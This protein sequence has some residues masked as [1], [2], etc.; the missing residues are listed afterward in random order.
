MC[1]RAGVA[2]QLRP[3]DLT[4]AAWQ[5]LAEQWRHWLRAHATGSFG[6]TLDAA[7]GRLCV[8]GQPAGAAPRASVH[9]LVD[10]V[11]GRMQVG[12]Q[13]LWMTSRECMRHVPDR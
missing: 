13:G 5:A 3:G 2:A 8:L 1:E 9:A 4:D 6:A 11:Y 12:L 7:S 10:A